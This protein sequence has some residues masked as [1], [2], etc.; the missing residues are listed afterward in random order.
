MRDVTLEPAGRLD[1]AHALTVW[2][3]WASLILLDFKPYEFRRWPAP[4]SFVS[5]RIAIHAARRACDAEEVRAIALD[6]ERT[7][8]G[9]DAAA[10]R[11]FGRSILRDG[12]AVPRGAIL[13]TVTLGEPCRAND[14]ACASR[15]VD[16][17]DPDIW[18]WPV[19]APRK[20]PQPVPARGKQGFWLWD[21]SRALDDNLPRTRSHKARGAGARRS[22]SNTAPRT[23]QAQTKRSG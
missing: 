21:Q 14:I 20:L 12:A 3:P 1:A 18:A 8:F 10:A 23:W 19:S 17:V 13:G 9:G 4:K 11:Q 6:P 16:L 5:R 7:C 22:R 15:D 2:Q